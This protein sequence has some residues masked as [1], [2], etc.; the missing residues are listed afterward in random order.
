MPGEPLPPVSVVV[1]VRNDAGAALRHR[2]ILSFEGQADGI[3]PDSI[4]EE[5]LQTLP[6]QLPKTSQ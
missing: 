1:P 3:E 2:M 4:I 5:V 6:Q